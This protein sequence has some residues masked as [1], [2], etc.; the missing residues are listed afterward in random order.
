MLVGLTFQL[1]KQSKVYFIASEVL[2]VLSL[3]VAIRL[4]RSFRQP[5]TFIASG[6]EA[7]KDKDF[8]I[9][10]VTTGNDEVDELIRVYNL[11]IDPAP[12]RA[13]PA[14]RAAVF[15]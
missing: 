3:Y 7:I 9:K 5:A 8:T 10:F 1:L 13:D 2:I 4:Y 14:G 12:A 11:M 6:I 15:S